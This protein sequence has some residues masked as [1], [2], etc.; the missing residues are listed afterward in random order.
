MSKH[1]MKKVTVIV[2]EDLLR[3][4]MRNSG[5]GFAPTIRL[6]LEALVAEDLA[7]RRLVAEAKK[8]SGKVQGEDQGE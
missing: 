2:P 4:A 5:Q 8:L 1:R 7:T 6:A 3:R